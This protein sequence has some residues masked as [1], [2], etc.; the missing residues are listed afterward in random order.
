MATEN[1]T[2]VLGPLLRVIEGSST[3]RN[4]SDIPPRLPLS[5]LTVRSFLHHGEEEIESQSRRIHL[6]VRVLASVVVV[7]IV[8]V[9]FDV[10][11]YWEQ[12]TGI[13]RGGTPLTVLALVKRLGSDIRDEVIRAD[14]K[15]SLHGQFVSIA[16][17]EHSA[18]PVEIGAAPVCK[19]KSSRDWEVRCSSEHHAL[20]RW[21][22][23]RGDVAVPC[24]HDQRS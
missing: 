17:L 9:E 16:P 15:S 21:G 5:V 18:F 23:R 2:A 3:G 6:L 20:L 1:V 4:V 11:A 19:A 13:E 10:P 7:L 12:A 22:I 24:F 8:G 14:R